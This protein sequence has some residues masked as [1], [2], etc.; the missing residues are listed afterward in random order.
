MV[1][2]VGAAVVA[3]RPDGV[4]KVNCS[5]SGSDDFADVWNSTVRKARKVHRC[6]ECREPIAIA[7][8]YEHAT[9][10]YDGHWSTHKR[11]LLCVEI[12]KYYAAPGEG[13]AIGELWERLADEMFPHMTMGGPCMEG[14]SVAA[15]LFLVDRRMDWLYKRER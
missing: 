8:R 2:G 14:L 13:L 11:C 10:L 9:S 12:A 4:R 7:Q 3:G 15:R 6:H 5:I 1:G